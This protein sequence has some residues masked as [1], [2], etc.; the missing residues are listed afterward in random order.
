VVK[1]YNYRD[2]KKLVASPR[3]VSAQRYAIGGRIN[4]DAECHTLFNQLTLP[5]EYPN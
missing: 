4:R 3:L 5:L 2:F 1:D